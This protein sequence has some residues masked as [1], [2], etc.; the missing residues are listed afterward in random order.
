M[1][2][3]GLHMAFLIVAV[4]LF[5]LSAIPPIPDYRLDRVGLAF[6]AAAFLVP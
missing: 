1:S 5:A 3:V 4:V 2:V 6:F